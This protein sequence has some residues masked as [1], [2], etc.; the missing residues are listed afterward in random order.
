MEKSPLRLQKMLL[1]LQRYGFNLEYKPGS[2]QVIPDALSRVAIKEEKPTGEQSQ[3]KVEVFCSSIDDS[4][5]EMY[6]DLRDSRIVSLRK[7]N[8]DDDTACRLREAIVMGWPLK[9][10]DCPVDIR[11]YWTFREELAFRDGLIYKGRRMVIPTNRVHEL[12]NALHAAHQGAES[13]MIR[14]R[15]I[16]YWPKMREDLEEFARRC[17]E[18][19]MVRP[20]NQKE[21][22]RTHE[23][24]VQPFS[25]VGT[26]MCFYKGVPYL[27]VVDY[28]TDYIEVEKLPDQSA[29]ETVE[30][31]K[32]I[33]ARHG[34]P[35]IVHSD[36]GSQYTAVEFKRFSAEWCFEHTVSSP[37]TSRSNGKAESAVKIVKKILKTS[38]D[39]LRGL[40]E[41]RASPNRDFTSPCE[42]LFNRKIRTFIPQDNEQLKPKVV[43]LEELRKQ[44]EGRQLRIQK[45]YNKAAKD[46]PSL[47]MGQPVLLRTVA[48]RSKKWKEATVLE[49]LSD[50]SYLVNNGDGILRRNRQMIQD[51]P[52][53]SNGYQ[54]GSG[55]ELTS[56]NDS[57]ERG[58]NDYHE[59]QSRSPTS[60]VTRAGRTS[61][62]PTYLDDY[63]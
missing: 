49:K 4:D 61:R 57:G 25:K 9:R 28:T 23:L 56:P 37:Y 12:C 2:Q 15:D 36:N 43:E 52:N 42:R 30:A 50:R 51:R 14:A 55:A 39:P 45:E 34:R 7:G 58:V 33:F 47:N 18:C 3:N 17:M 35:L 62:R 6:T 31:C 53:D 27:V 19:A 29:A 16:V 63:E 21:T 40:M 54:A 32:R 59:E 22:L 44:R 38:S 48:D 13:M 5:P 26:D 8:K 1:T 24:P 60:I 11:D 20:N 41:W 10:K 46:L